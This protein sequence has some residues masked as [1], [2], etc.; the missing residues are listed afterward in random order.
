M[1]RRLHQD[2]DTRI[3]RVHELKTLRL[4]VTQHIAE[5]KSYEIRFNDRDFQLNDDLLLRAISVGDDQSIAYT[6]EWVFCHVQSI[7]T[8]TQFGMRDGFVIMSTRKI[9][10]G[11]ADDWKIY[12]NIK[13]HILLKQV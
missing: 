2:P 1:G 8:D 4:F 9:V 7:L 11:Y 10:H 5:Q 6:G 13:N 12:P 3:K